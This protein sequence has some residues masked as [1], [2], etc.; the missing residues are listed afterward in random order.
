MIKVN[1]L[2]KDV[3][4]IGFLNSLPI[5]CEHCGSDT[6]ISE[7]L[8]I[9]RCSNDNCKETVVQ[10]MV[11]MLKDIGVKDMGESR[12]RGFVDKFGVDTPY[13]ILGY[14]PNIDGTLTDNCSIEFSNNVY[15]SIQRSNTM[16]LWEY[17]KI[18]N[19][20][21]IRDSARKIFG[22]YTDLN[23]FYN[24]LEDKGIDLVQDLLGIKGSSPIDVDDFDD[25]SSLG[26]TKK[27]VV[28]VRAY[29]V[30]N[31]LVKN[32]GY[33]KDYIQYIKLKEVMNWTLSICISSSVG[34]PFKSKGDFVAA[35]NSKYSNLVN[36]NLMSSVTK[37]CDAL[38][39][40]GYGVPT[41]KVEKA[42]KYG[43]K[44]Y[45]GKEFDEYL[46]SLED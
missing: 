29:D 34:E 45:T 23:T 16:M 44:V 12:C 32:K 46:E 37:N 35:M 41:S 33:L 7:T 38:I 2:S 4:P 24:D 19:M 21:N 27:E 40:S 15:E 13:A 10:R 9:L 5:K 28:S 11:M 39:W 18:G 22:E 30:F 42:K 25:I 14:E 36:I 1:E 3:F 43:I 20:P 17:V 31:T 26:I 6:E 8:T